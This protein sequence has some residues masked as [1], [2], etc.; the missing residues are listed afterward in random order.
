MQPVMARPAVKMDCGVGMYILTRVDRSFVYKLFLLF[1]WK[2]YPEKRA[3][4][5]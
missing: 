4:P 1:C 3:K 2:I 5:I